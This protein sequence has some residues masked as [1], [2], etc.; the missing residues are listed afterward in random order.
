MFIL[1]ILIA[2]LAL[3]EM[4]KSIKYHTEEYETLIKVTEELETKGGLSIQD[5]QRIKQTLTKHANS[6][7]R[8]NRD[9][10]NRLLGEVDAR[11]RNLETI[12]RLLD[13]E[14]LYK[15]EKK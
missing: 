12:Q 15:G 7:N 11:I 6:Y 4:G 13:E 3:G 9:R 5:L 8:P 2:V 10:C 1:L 14:K